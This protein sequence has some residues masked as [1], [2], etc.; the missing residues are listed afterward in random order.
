[1]R[2]WEQVDSG[3]Q[4]LRRIKVKSLL[5]AGTA[6]MGEAVLIKGWVRTVRRGPRLALRLTVILCVEKAGVSSQLH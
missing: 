2:L 1:M 6:L 5:S 3:V 4:G